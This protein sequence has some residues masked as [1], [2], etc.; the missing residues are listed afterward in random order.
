LPHLQL[1]TIVGNTAFARP[2]DK[3]ATL[4][5]RAGSIPGPFGAARLGMTPWGR[6]TGR[7]A[8]SE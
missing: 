5:I 3:F 6:P 4:G 2:L 7:A 8:R 1:D